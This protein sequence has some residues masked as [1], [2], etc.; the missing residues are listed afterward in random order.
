[1]NFGILPLKLML[2]EHFI[3]KEL[4]DACEAIRTGRGRTKAVNETKYPF[5]LRGLLKCSISGRMVSCDI[6]K[7]KH[8]YLISRDPA[9]PEKKIW[10]NEK[11]VMEQI[12]DVFKSIQIPEDVLADITGHLKKTH[13]SEKDYHQISVK[14]LTKESELVTKR[15]DVLLDEYLDK[16]ILV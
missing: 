7:G 5:I 11:I 3:T 2:Y 15:L 8:I 12:R 1:M 6:K 16:S 9:N 4:F 14:N 10:T 13:Q